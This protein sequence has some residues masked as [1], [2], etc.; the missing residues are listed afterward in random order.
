MS[1]HH[2]LA[3]LELKSPGGP[4]E[5]VDIGTPSNIIVSPPAASIKRGNFVKFILAGIGFLAILAAFTVQFTQSLGL[6]TQSKST[7]PLEFSTLDSESNNNNNNRTFPICVF[8]ENR[9]LYSI[10]NLDDQVGCL[11]RMD[12]RE[13]TP[14]IDQLAS[15]N[16]HSYLGAINQFEVLQC[17]R[18]E[19]TYRTC[20]GSCSFGT[21]QCSRN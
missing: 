19:Q 5:R 1:Q 15:L 7:A 11:M 17:E 3:P 4:R 20:A 21:I 8:H 6:K 12:S 10:E 14:V 16:I 18:Y 9:N 2:N 13:P